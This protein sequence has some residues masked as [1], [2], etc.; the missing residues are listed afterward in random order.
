[1][2]VYKKKLYLCK[3]LIIMATTLRI[4]TNSPEAVFYGQRAGNYSPEAA[5]FGNNTNHVPQNDDEMFR[6]MTME[7]YRAMIDEAMEDKRAGRYI[8]HEDMGKLIASWR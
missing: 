1:V 5:N 2:Q 4:N 3:K 7:E 6:P 8:S